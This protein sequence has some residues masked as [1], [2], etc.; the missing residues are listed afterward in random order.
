MT[1]ICS[2]WSESGG[3]GKTTTAVSLAMLAA[4]EGHR[5]L[6]V[7]LDPRA[8][9]TKW[10]EITPSQQGYHVGAILAAENPAGWADELAVA[11]TW[12]ENLSVIPSDRSVANREAEKPDGGETRLRAALMGTT[13]D[14]VLIDCPNRQGGMLAM[15][16]LMASGSLVYSATP[17]EDGVDGIEGARQT[18]AT[19]ARSQQLRGSTL[20]PV[21]LGAVI[22]NVRDTVIPK[23]ERA[24]IEYINAND[25]ALKPFIPTREAV[26]QAR[27]NGEWYGQP[28]YDRAE[29]VVAAYREVL[30]T[31]LERTPDQ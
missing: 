30:H 24:S 10:L 6:L 4:Q 25:L 11:S 14:V 3:V 27:Y 15:N 22:T 26:R 9:S 18:L 28:G 19:F 23:V 29:P 5:S 31:I 1:K 8:A 7:D 20:I 16:A 2:V 17:T 21:D 12:H 13:A